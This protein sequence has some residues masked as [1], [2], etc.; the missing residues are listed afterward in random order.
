VEILGMTRKTGNK[1][2]TETCG[3]C[4]QAHSNYS[5]KLDKNDIEYVICGATNK[6]MIVSGYG[7]VGF[8]SVYPTEWIKENDFRGDFGN[9]QDRI[10]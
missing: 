1:Y 3:R 5:G 7:I 9:E 4:G 10:S 2:K 6:R 8:T